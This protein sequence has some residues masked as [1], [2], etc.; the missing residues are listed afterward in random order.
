[1]N[2]KTVAVLF[3]GKSPEHEVSIITAIQ[4]M[5]ALKG[6]GHEALPVYISKE[7][8][9][10][11]GD[12]SFW[13]PKTF[14]DQKKAI[15]KKPKIFLPVG[16]AENFY[17]QELPEYFSF[18][19]TQQKFN[20]DIAFPCLH[21]RNGEDGSIQGV[22]E[23]ANVPYVGCGVDSSAIGID[24]ALS[25]NIAQNLG[26]PVLQ[27][28]ILEKG[29]KLPLGIKYPVYVKPARLGSS[30]GISRA[31]NET[32]LKDALEVAYFYDTKVLIEEAAKDFI[33]VNISL[34]GNGPYEASPTEQPLAT[35]E[36]L[37]FEDKYL[38]HERNTK[39][40]A[41]AKRKIPAP[42]KNATTKKIQDYAK[43]F[44]KTINGKGICRIDFIVSKDEKKVYFNEI[45]TLPGSLSFYLWKEAGVSFS[46]LVD[47]LVK[48]GLE[49][50]KQ[51]Q[52]LITTFESNILS[53]FKGAKAV[54]L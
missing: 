26:I 38:S 21:G 8:Q 2:K 10:Y 35:S 7:G 3:G 25:K 18:F 9:W 45:N 20:F 46:E 23:L 22:L 28:I 49:E 41:T 50:Y 53:S 30:I 34:I 54:K 40:M 19:K 1:M 29:Q 51:K 5:Y 43:Q 33:E 16:Q 39:G 27:H 6:A 32:E 52:N 17:L 12:D 36:I 44:F 11:L 48:F 31:N 37:S 24:K 14:S 47:K 42:I 4:L 13:D 15:Y